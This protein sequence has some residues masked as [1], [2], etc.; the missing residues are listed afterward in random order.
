LNQHEPG[1]PPRFPI[2]KQFAH[3]CDHI[4]VRAGTKLGLHVTAG[5]PRTRVPRLG[6]M[7]EAYRDPEYLTVTLADGRVFQAR[8]PT[9][10]DFDTAAKDLLGQLKALTKADGDKA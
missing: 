7:P 9:K 8:M 4:D 1:P 6:A 3:L 10:D 5:K 2:P